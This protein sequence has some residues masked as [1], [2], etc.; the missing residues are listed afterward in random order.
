VRWARASEL[1]LAAW[2]LASSAWFAGTTWVELSV[3]IAVAAVAAVALA[4]P[5]GHSHLWQLA[6]AAVLVGSGWLAARGEADGASQNRIV[7][8]LLL[9][10]FA[11]VPTRAFEPPPAWRDA[12]DPRLGSGET[13]LRPGGHGI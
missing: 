12:P 8:G 7:V 5:D 4:D 13:P 10:T 6:F 9:A 2:L 3:A 1:L 11:L